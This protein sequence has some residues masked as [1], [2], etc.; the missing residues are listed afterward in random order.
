MVVAKDPVLTRACSREDKNPTEKD[1]LS[2]DRSVD[3]VEL[4]LLQTPVV[5]T[6]KIPEHP[7]HAHV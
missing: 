6:P 3:L 1:A 5:Y 4:L 7:Q 2:D